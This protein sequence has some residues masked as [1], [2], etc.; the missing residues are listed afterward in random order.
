MALTH[1][2]DN[3]VNFRN[4]TYQWVDAQRF[5]RTDEEDGDDVLAA[6]IGHDLFGRDYAG[7][8]AGADPERHGPYWRKLITPQSYR[9]VDADDAVSRLRIWAEQHVRVSDAIWMRLETE[10]YPLFGTADEVHELRDLG[11]TAHHDWGGVQN[12]FHEFVLVEKTLV[13][14]VVA[15]DD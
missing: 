2:G 11:T 4:R 8:A 15:A 14:L 7:G 13:T 10:I 6:V 1:E 5:L 12:D 9:R 3:F